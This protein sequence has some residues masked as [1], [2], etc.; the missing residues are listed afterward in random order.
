MRLGVLG[1]YWN[2][3]FAARR[4][5]IRTTD[6]YLA[7]FATDKLAFEP[8]TRELYSNGGYIILGKVIEVVFRSELS[9]L[10]KEVP[11]PLRPGCRTENSRGRR[12]GRTGRDRLHNSDAF[13]GQQRR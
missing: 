3:A 7:L 9:R 2:D 12:K 11:L 4:A 10:C 13:A 6:D 8:G 1:S 5:S